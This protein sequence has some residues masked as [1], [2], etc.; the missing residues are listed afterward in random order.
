[1]VAQTPLERLVRV[2]TS[3]GQPI[4]AGSSME[5]QCSGRAKV[6]GSS[7]IRVHQF[8]YGVLAQFWKSS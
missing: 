3:N 6:V 5:E 7:P 1:M 8:S 2:R 4:W